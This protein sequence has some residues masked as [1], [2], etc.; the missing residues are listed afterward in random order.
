MAKSHFTQL[1]EAKRGKATPQMKAV[2]KAEGMPLA[3]LRTLIASGRLVIPA[4]RVHIERGLKPIGIGEG[5]SVKINA[6]IGASQENS[7]VQMELEKARV[8]AKY[9]ADTLMDL[10][11]GVKN[12]DEIRTEIISHS[13]MPVGT[14]PIYQAVESVKNLEDLTSELILKVI[15]KQARQGVDYMTIHAGI[16]KSHSRLA[17]NRVTGIVSRGGALINGWMANTGMENPL[18]TGFAD[19]LGIAGEYDVTISLGDSL[20]PGSIAD[21]TDRAQ[22]AELKTLGRL[23]KEC[24]KAGVQSMV[25]GPGHIPMHMIEKNVK[26]EKKYCF[27]APFYVLGPLVCDIGAGYDH[28]TAAIG[29]AIAA[30]HGADFLCYVTPKEHLG[31]PDAEDVRQGI[32]ASKIAAHAADIARG[33]PGSAKRDREMSKARYDMD[34]E[35]QISLALDPERAAQY[36]KASGLSVRADFCS[37]CGPKFCAMRLHHQATGKKTFNQRGGVPGKK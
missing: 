2:A 10:S 6:N 22:L 8:C 19:I 34:W 21:N 14:V 4:N 1:V 35:R 11:A 5:A 13:P 25:E 32:I 37:M 36:R 20:R 23:V 18:Y 26:L 27:G 30:Y 28:I 3:R 17:R 7:C 31:L 33:I 24:R 9:G 29:G 15:E 16:L 12:L